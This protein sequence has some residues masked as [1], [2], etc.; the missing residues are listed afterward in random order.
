MT[1]T[2]ADWT[3]T[4]LGKIGD[5]L[6]GLTYDP[7]A[8]R[9]AGTLVLRSSNVQDGALAFDDNV[10][11]DCAIPERIRVRNGDILIC[12]RNGSRRLIGKSAVLDKRVEGETFGAFMTVFRSDANPYLRY[13]FQSGDFKRQI[14]EHLG[15]TINQITNGSLKSFV[16]ALPETPE[17]AAIAERLN[18]ADHLISVLQHLTAKRKRIRQGMM[19]KLLTGQ[20]RLPGFSGPWST[21]PLGKIGPLLKGRGIKRDDVQ[22]HGVACIRYGEIY[23]TYSGYTSSTISYVSKAIAAKALPIRPGDL[24][25]A[26]SGETREE[27]GTCVAFT[28]TQ[29]AVAGGDILVLRAS[30]V[31]PIYV[32]SLANTPVVA[33]Q[34]ARLGQGDAV[35]H[36]NS[37]ALASIEIDLPPAD[38]QNAIASVLVDVDQEIERLERRIA[39]ATAMKQGMMQQLLTGRTRLAVT[40][41]AT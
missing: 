30:G 4:K 21:Q 25:F 14:D 38:E 18:D 17:R 41:A 19:Q 31:N 36:I 24:L 23:T 10:Y 34:K 22:T 12:V 1:T 37:R 28:G 35:V 40:E 29:P 5:A 32:A 6:I 9:R 27:I 2:P 26:G 13:F 15:A 16:V 33:A 3:T 11:V 20:A 39:K 8:I 7:G